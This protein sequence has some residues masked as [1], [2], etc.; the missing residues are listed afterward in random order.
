LLRRHIAHAAQG[1]SFA[2]FYKFCFAW[3]VPLVGVYLISEIVRRS[4][5]YQSTRLTAF[6]DIMLVGTLSGGFC[7]VLLRKVY[8]RMTDGALF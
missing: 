5:I 6:A 8:F 3:C 1:F 2:A 4:G 7:L